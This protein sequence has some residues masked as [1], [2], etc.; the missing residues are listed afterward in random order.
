[1]LIEPYKDRIAEIL[2]RYPE[3]RAALL[4]LLWLAQETQGYVSEEAMREI[5][6]LLDLTPPQ[7]F[8]TV[9]FYSMYNLRPIGRFHIQVCRSLMCA[10]VGAENLLSWIDAKLG[11]KT[12]G[13]T[14]D[15]MFSLHQVECLASC[16]TGPMM[17]INDEYY[18]RLTQA[19]VNR[20]LDDLRRD[21]KSD[22]ASGPFMF[23]EP[24]NK[25]SESSCRTN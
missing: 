12:G 4:P 15:R 11:L 14:P 8:E 17:Q 9:T 21:G 5:A 10:L 2:D 24:S 1:M 7:V 22:L 13:T 16:G 25:S 3:K 19:K 23:P 18:E 20:I 6:G